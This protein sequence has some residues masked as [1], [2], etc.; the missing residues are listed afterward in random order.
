MNVHYIHYIVLVRV[1][2]SWGYKNCGR[3]VGG[4]SHY[5]P[6]PAAP[7]FYAYTQSPIIIVVR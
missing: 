6:T 3:S 5:A 2:F 1:D 7:D 4:N